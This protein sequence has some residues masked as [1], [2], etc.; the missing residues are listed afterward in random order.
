MNN[1]TILTE[2]GKTIGF[3][4]YTRCSSLYQELTNAGNLVRFVV[5]ENEYAINDPNIQ[6]MN[7]LKS[8]DSVSTSST[9][10]IVIID[11]YLADENSY[12][13]LA[14]RFHK[15]VAIDDNNRMRYPVD[16]VINP[17][18]FFEDIDYSNQTAVCLGGKDYVILRPEFINVESSATDND[19]LQNILITIGGS[20]FRNLLPKLI[21]ICKQLNGATITVINP[22]NSIN[23]Q[24]N[25]KVLP[26][27]SAAQMVQEMQRADVV[28]SACGQTLHEL[29]ALQKP[30]IGICLD[31]DQIH[32]QIFYINH[33]FLWEA[34][35]WNDENI[36]NKIKEHLTIF[37]L[38]AN[39]K[40]IS[41][42][43]KSLISKNGA[44]R[45]VN[46]I[47]DIQ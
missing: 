29:V 2:A 10:D 42:I 1:V 16:V 7:W 34:I 30:T 8:I 27:Q 40:S 36:E 31:S 41:D 4:H 11:S 3:G 5:Y 46:Y 25:V 14:E 26:A 23:D 35:K 12:I 38:S 44:Q 9:T 33:G 20:D 21:S 39:R 43:C 37:K 22:E 32:N 24:D 6:S 28:I 17:N 47:N 18:V 19:S 13:Q 45:I 15:V